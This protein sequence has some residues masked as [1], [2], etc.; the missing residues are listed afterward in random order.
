[1]VRNETDVEKRSVSWITLPWSLWAFPV[2]GTTLTAYLLTG[3][4]EV[5]R[6][7]RTNRPHS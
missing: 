5:R 1:M 3:T 6:L 4:K 2:L 7:C